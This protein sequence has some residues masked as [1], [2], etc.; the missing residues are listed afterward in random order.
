MWIRHAAEVPWAEIGWFP[1]VAGHPHSGSVDPDKLATALSALRVPDHRVRSLIPWPDRTDVD[2]ALTEGKLVELP[3]RDT[4][5]FRVVATAAARDA[6][7]RETG[8]AGPGSS[9]DQVLRSEAGDACRHAVLGG[10]AAYLRARHWKATALAVMCVREPD[11][12]RPRD[13]VITLWEE[14]RSDA[15]AA[16][17]A[18]AAWWEAEFSAGRDPSDG[19]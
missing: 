5:V 8:W 1:P 10:F 17:A 13:V 9:P 4:S 16:A 11:G 7:T 18:E 19:P 14:V 12:P 2:Q 15:L 6:L 3:N